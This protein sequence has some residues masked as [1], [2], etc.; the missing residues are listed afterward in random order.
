MPWSF[1]VLLLE[2][3]K[4]SGAWQRGQ[5]Q[6]PKVACGMGKRSPLLNFLENQDLETSEEK[7]F[8]DFDWLGEKDENRFLKADSGSFVRVSFHCPHVGMQ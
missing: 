1:L 8:Q 6:P 7:T 3:Y 5:P 2:S 4:F